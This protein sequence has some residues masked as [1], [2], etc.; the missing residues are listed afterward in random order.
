MFI[1]TSNLQRIE[2]HNRP[3][4][5]SPGGSDM[6]SSCYTVSFGDELL[7]DSHFTLAAGTFVV[8]L[9]HIPHSN[10]LQRRPSEFVRFA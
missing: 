4:R 3:C 7:Y 2:L 10:T 9:H 6:C 5:D 8:Y 1:A